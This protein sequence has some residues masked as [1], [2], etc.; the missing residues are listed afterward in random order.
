[1]LLGKSNMKIIH[2]E[3]NPEFDQLQNI[4]QPKLA[5]GV[6]RNRETNNPTGVY[7]RWT[8]I[9]QNDTNIYLHCVAEDSYKIND[10]QDFSMFDLKLLLS[11]SFE[12]FKVVFLERLDI[13]GVQV[14]APTFQ[15]NDSML[16]PLLQELKK[17]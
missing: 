1:M 6:T 2:W 14:S 13:I 5:A 12:N 7:F 17:D 9:L 4:G 10:F 8:Y 15:I 11:K 3:Y 16:Q